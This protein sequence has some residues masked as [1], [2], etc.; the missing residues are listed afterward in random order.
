MTIQ[1]QDYRSLIKLYSEIE[2]SVSPDTLKK[3]EKA[4]SPAAEKI[5]KEFFL[6][7]HE[8]KGVKSRSA[9]TFK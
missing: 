2:A 9:C 8:S 4:D 6:V 5:A 1:N 7:A 3:V